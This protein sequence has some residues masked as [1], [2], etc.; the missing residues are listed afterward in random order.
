MSAH[1]RGRSPS[2]PTGEDAAAADA[3]SA[4]VAG[5]LRIPLAHLLKKSAPIDMAG[6]VQRTPS[7]TKKPSGPAWGAGGGPEGA[8]PATSGIHPSLRSIQVCPFCIAATMPRMGCQNVCRASRII[9]W[10]M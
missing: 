7:E 5:G 6:S 8:S 1:A 3:G 4:E 10:A 9:R 2:L